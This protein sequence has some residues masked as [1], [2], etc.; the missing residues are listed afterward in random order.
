MVTTTIDSQVQR[1]LIEILRIL[2][3][4]H[5]PIGARLIADRMNE[6]GYPIGERG[7]RYHLRILDE[8]GLTQRQGYDGRTITERGINE[9]NN[10]LVGDRLGFIITRIEKLI[11]DTTFD[12][13]TGEGKVIINTSII[14]KKDLD[15]TMGILRDVMYNGYPISPYIKLIDEG[16][17]TSDIKVPEG[18]IGIATMCSITIDGILLKNGIPVNTKYGG[19]LEVKEKN[20]SVLMISLSITVLP[21]T[22]CGF[23]SHGK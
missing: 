19:I 16:T 13:K 3:E 18:K 21:S 17:M 20:R 15:K 10:A 9:L 23:S 22:R 5:D 7:V 14:D 12:L 4:N 1:K 6:R 11:Y 2:Y 8:R